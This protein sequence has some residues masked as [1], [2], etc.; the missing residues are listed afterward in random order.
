M[1]FKSLELLGPLKE[2]GLF[3]NN[4]LKVWFQPAKCSGLLNILF[5]VAKKMQ[6]V[7]FVRVNFPAGGNSN[8]ETKV[9]ILFYDD[10][11]EMNEGFGGFIPSSQ[12]QVV[13]MLEGSPNSVF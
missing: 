9:I 5:P 11:T 7:L 13:K 2:K 1:T 3:P 12:D 6:P 10:M 8:C 4:C